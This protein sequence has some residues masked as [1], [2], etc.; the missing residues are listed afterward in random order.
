MAG[1]RQADG[2]WQEGLSSIAMSPHSR[3]CS[4]VSLLASLL[5]TSVAVFATGCLAPVWYPG[6]YTRG[7]GEYGYGGC[8]YGCGS[9]YGYG[10]ASP[11]PYNAYYGSGRYYPYGHDRDDDDHHHHHDDGGWYGNG[12]RG[13]QQNCGQDGGHHH[14]GGG[15]SGHDRA[16]GDAQRGPSQQQ[17]AEQNRGRGE[18]AAPPPQPQP[19]SQASEQARNEQRLEVRRDQMR[20][21]VRMRPEIRR[22]VEEARD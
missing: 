8:R 19:E 9:S 18:R 2:G 6:G 21:G 16:R 12:D 3:W 7:Y 4:P 14:G 11:R 13:Q 15:D 5:L 20:R 22:Q 10:Y 1:D 17:Q